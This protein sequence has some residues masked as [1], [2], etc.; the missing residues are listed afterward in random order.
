MKFEFQNNTDKDVRGVQGTLKLF[1][2]FGD[3]ISRVSLSYDEGIPA[4]QQQIYEAGTDFNQFSDSDVKL[5]ETK[6]E[7][8]EFE[9]EIDSVIYA[10]GSQEEI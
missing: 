6:L 10:D 8:L 5:K 4:G 1:D 9:W 3:R 7:N 2:I